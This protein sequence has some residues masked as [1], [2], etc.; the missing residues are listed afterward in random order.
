LLR[1]YRERGRA[2]QG[3]LWQEQIFNATDDLRQIAGQTGIALPTPAVAWVL[4]NPTI[5]SPIIGAGK[6]EQLEATLQFR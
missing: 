5:T 6:P 1:A 2:L 3:S 4:T